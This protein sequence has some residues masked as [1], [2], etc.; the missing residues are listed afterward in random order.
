MRIL[1]GNPHLNQQVCRDIL[2]MGFDNAIN[3]VHV[4]FSS[5]SQST[6]NEILG[7][8]RIFFGGRSRTT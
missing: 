7:S 6:Y 3:K 1:L 5:V 2:G 4:V 8:D